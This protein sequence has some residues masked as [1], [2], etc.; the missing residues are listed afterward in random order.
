MPEQDELDLL[1]RSALSTYGDPGPES[2]LEKRILAHIA[3]EGLAATKRGWLPWAIALP[4]AAGLLL[5][6]VLSGSR[7][8]RPLIGHVDQTPWQQ[9]TPA[10]AGGSNAS[11]ASRTAATRRAKAPLVQPSPRMA[12]VT[13]KA[14]PLPK[15]DVFPSPQPLSPEE[16]ALVDFAA[17]APKSEL[18]ALADAQSQVDAPISIA[19]IQ[20]Q[21]LEP[22]DQGEN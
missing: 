16:Q 1:V 19:A 21:P 10:N 8:T 7:H 3:A 5:L 6:L 18:K 2:G 22:P 14:A 4:V 17:H 13:A 11:T 15:L 9:H 20:I 12:A